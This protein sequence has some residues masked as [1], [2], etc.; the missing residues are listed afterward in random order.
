MHSECPSCGSMNIDSFT[1]SVKS[2]GGGGIFGG[3]M[4]GFIGGKNDGKEE[5][6]YQCQDCGH[7]WS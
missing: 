1:R 4:D 5:V 7:E 3:I 2:G 6:Y